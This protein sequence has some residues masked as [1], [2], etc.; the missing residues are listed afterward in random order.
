MQWYKG[1]HKIKEGVKYTSHYVQIAADEF[2]VRLE[3]NV[4]VKSK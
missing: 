1:N 4:S 3:I 2:E